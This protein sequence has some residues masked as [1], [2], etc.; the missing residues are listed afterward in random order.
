M[1]SAVELVGSALPPAY[2][3]A[4]ALLI[5]YLSRRSINL[6][7]YEQLRE[8]LD[9]DDQVNPST[10]HRS[11]G[12][13]KLSNSTAIDSIHAQLESRRASGL[14]I[15]LARFG[16]TAL[17]LGLAILTATLIHKGKSD[18][19]QPEESHMSLEDGLKALAWLYALVLSL[20][21]LIKPELSYQFSLRPQMDCFYLL[22]LILSSIQL[23]AGGILDLPVSKWPFS[24]KMVD[25]AWLINTLLITVSL[26]TKPY[27]SLVPVRIPKDGEIIRT[28]SIEYASSFYSQIA[29][30]W[31]NP[32]IYLGYQR[33]V[34]DADLPDLEPTDLSENSARKFQVIKK[35]TFT[36]SLLTA[37][38]EDL[39]LQL[40]W[41]IPFSI[42]IIS[43]PY[44][45]NKLIKYVECKECGAPTIHEY[46][47]VF[48]L[49]F[50]SILKSAAMQ[51]CLHR[52]R[53]LY[54]HMVSICNSQ[55]FAKALRRKDMTSSAENSS[56]DSE[57]KEKKKNRTLNIS[58]LVGVDVR[59]MEETFCYMHDLY[60][61]PIQF[62]LSAYQ[63]Y[64]LLG[65][66][67]WI[68]IGFMIITL[69]IPG[70]LY[71]VFTKLFDSIMSSKDDRMD[72]LNEMLSAIR[73][74]KFFG[75][76]SKFVEKIT[77]SREKELGHIRKTYVRTALAGIAWMIV[78]LFN[79][80]VFFFAYS[81]IYG[82]DISASVL[83]TTLSLFNIMTESLTQIPWSITSIMRANVSLKRIAKF[84]D[85]DEIARDT[86]ITR[87]DGK[88]R[89]HSPSHPI[90]GFVNASFAWPN[91]ETDKADTKKV[92]KKSWFQKLMNRSPEVPVAEPEAVVERFR[93]KNISI[94]FPPGQLSLIVGATGS[95]K[96]ALLLALL[97]ELD[98]LEGEVYMPR[99]D[100]GDSYA[101]DHSSGIAYV[102]Q[103]AWLQS[104]TIRDNILF[105][106]EFDQARYDDVIEGCALI[107][108]LQIFEDGDATEIGELGIT[109][110][111]GQKQ[112][113]ALARAIYSDS[114]ILL[115]DDCLSAVDTHTGEKIFQTLVGPLL[116]DRT[117][118]MVT[119]QVQLTLNAAKYVVVL[120]KGEVL[121]TGTPEVVL[122]NGWIDNVAL[123]TPV[124]DDSSE[125]STL[126]GE[127]RTKKSKKADSNKVTTKL[128]EDEKRE[129]GSV[130]FNVYLTYLSAS[131]GW[132]FWIG[133]VGFLLLREAL[134]FANNA[135][136]AIWGNRMAEA[137]G[138]FAIAMFNS[139]MPESLALSVYSAFAPKNG[140]NNFIINSLFGDGEVRSV[141]YYLGIYILIS[142]AMM[143]CG[144]VSEFYAMVVGNIRGSRVIHTKLLYKISRAKIRFFDTTPI[145]RIINRFSADMSTIDDNVL[146][147]IESLLSNSVM[148]LGIVFTISLSTPLF[149]VAG[150]FIIGIYAVIGALYLPIS[151]DLKRLNSISKS[152][153]LNHFN[154]TLTGV[155]T[156]RAFGFE[157]RFL[158]KN[159]VN[160]DNNNRTFFT[161]WST[162]RWLHWRVDVTGAL[163]SFTTGILIL[164]NWDSIAPGWA[165]MSLSYSLRFTTKIVWV[166][167]NYAEN[168]MNMNAVERVCEYMALEE[169][170]PAI[171]EG[172]RPP[173]S[174][175]HAGQIEVDHLTMRY[176]PNTPE[177][178]KDISF[179][180]NAGE[181]VGVVG[182]TGSG[183]S[184]LA[185]S[186][187]RF[188]EPSQGT[189][190]IDGIDI[191]KIGLQDL[192]S[193]LTIIPQDPILFKG[194]LRSNLDPFGEHE[195]RELWEAI[196]RSHL[197]PAE[198]I[199]YQDPEVL[200]PG[201]NTSSSGKSPAISA[202]HSESDETDTVDPSKI[203]L[204]TP[205]KENGSNFSQGQ[206]QL[207]ALARALVRQPKIIIMDEATAS[208]DFETDLK[209]QTTIREEMA[210]ATMITI[211]H[212]IRTIADFD[213]VLVMDA[214]VIA[215]YDKPYT[216]L[217]K[218]GSL[219][220]SMCEHSS[221]FDALLAIAKA[222]AEKDEQHH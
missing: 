172:S 168:E 38:R 95:G 204:D 148:I 138:S 85:E 108:D 11:R 156:I 43:Q 3:L 50:T 14:A 114:K 56:E 184:T 173:A 133:V 124:S 152:P 34:Q 19:G 48:V 76:E 160:L 140:G 41:S 139:F 166:I 162:N 20:I 72:Y 24:L 192:R 5:F 190:H 71:S 12:Y 105:G 145:G 89:S 134:T 142:F 82:N 161:L 1:S 211:A 202:Q 66:A 158:S 187:F 46:A 22:Q 81:K 215:E 220:R 73:I 206:R 167:R 150:V 205:V 6:D 101:T 40:L 117:V 116:K 109:L 15:N 174:W 199:K 209:I 17:Q 45:L 25:A 96:S 97:G 100:Y 52:G 110:S 21:H 122:R 197:I 107:S 111:G 155:A 177:V 151:R 87:I 79:I 54:V 163:V 115:L 212:R 219:F 196:R 104:S 74:V 141:E 218:E 203:D 27:R 42:L 178:I 136:L 60:G 98:R 193:N 221:E 188:M 191:C 75:W 102:S 36:R 207:I 30:S 80:V 194:T 39:I 181:K 164:R 149:L 175:P 68:G 121:G 91:K 63:M 70:F 55:V 106:K 93:L 176:A 185:I 165:A 57:N 119:H 78:P 198:T 26:L 2:S 123:S 9:S 135:W 94:D 58:N 208:V 179:K 169:E 146:H 69:P 130:S 132:P 131:G 213:R 103:T 144:A 86:V 157:Q 35:K 99:S 217:Q 171:I 77:A 112:R 18:E 180:I 49:F 33:T 186:L 51:Q 137:T 210:D 216:L 37:L 44:C 129:I 159:L 29:F 200:V 127:E 13:I 201:S 10:N 120:S 23:Y 4:S 126:D 67:S 90:I 8:I 189:I 7:Q 65:D 125:V 28:P 147:G 84:L 31:V 61:I 83:F 88:S 195:D 214:G 153:I 154:E 59:K 143:I 222:K 182:R 118:V 62:G 64:D 92:S 128:I 47:W 183:K 170:A 53:R 113:V 16:L 32:L